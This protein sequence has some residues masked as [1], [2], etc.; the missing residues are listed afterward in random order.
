MK[1]DELSALIQLLDDPDNEVFNHVASK[2]LAMGNPV[3]PELESA[4]EDSIDP[5]L[6]ERIEDLIQLDDLSSDLMDWLANDPDNLLKGYVLA[7]R[8][9]Y[10]EMDEENI[11]NTIDSIK[12]AVWLEQ[13]YDLTPMEQVNVFNHILY[14]LKGFK[15]VTP[16]KPQSKDF[17][18]NQVVDSKMGNSMSLGLL[19]LILAQELDIPIYG[20]QLPR[21]FVLAYTRNFIHDFSEENLQKEVVF[22]INPANKGTIFSRNEIK[23]YL[24]KANIEAQKEFFSPISNLEV[25]KALFGYLIE[26]YELENDLSSVEELKE[27]RDLLG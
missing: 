2:L 11:R 25:I 5:E 12:R 4:W 18:L 3:I 6:Q 26:V 23:L 10:P 21:F 27:L 16:S 20:V 22:Y 14:T 7:S 13:N 24:E 9:R 8:Y 15:G 19:Y 17:Y 1:K